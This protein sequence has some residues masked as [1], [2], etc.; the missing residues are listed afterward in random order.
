MSEWHIDPAYE[1]LLKEAGILA[2]SDALAFANGTRLSRKSHSRTWLY[3]RDQVRLFIKQDSSTNLRTSLRALIRFSRPLAATQK[4]RARMMHLST[5]GFRVAQVVAYG[6]DT[7]F[8]LPSTAVL[9][10]LP[11]P[12]RSVSQIWADPTVPEER[13]REARALA[14]QTLTQLQKR[15]CDWGKDCKPEHFFLSEDNHITLIDVERMHFYSSPLS[16]T[17]CTGQFQRF[18]S[19]LEPKK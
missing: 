7:S 11:A 8:G 5:L 9:I 6:S 17:R 14:L 3:Q 1:S 4:E 10:T 16:E 13:R 18:N 19:L 12:G 15:G 2:Y